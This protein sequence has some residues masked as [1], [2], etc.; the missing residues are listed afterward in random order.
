MVLD[1]CDAHTTFETHLEVY[2]ACTRTPAG[3]DGC[4]ATEAHRVCPHQDTVAF[5]A[6]RGRTYHIFVTGR[7][8]TPLLDTGVFRLVLNATELPTASSSSSSSLLPSSS[9]HPNKGGRSPGQVAA[10]V[11]FGVLLPVALVVAAGVC[12]CRRLGCG[13]AG[14]GHGGL[15]LHRYRSVGASDAQPD[16]DGAEYQPVTL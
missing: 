2:R 14:G 12:L 7:D 1:T 4:V 6:E 15:T 8:T 3:G 10:I 9:D 13:G 5:V 11:V 16:S